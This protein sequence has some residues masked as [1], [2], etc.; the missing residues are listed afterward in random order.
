MR[1]KMAKVVELVF[2]DNWQGLYIDDKLAMCDHSLD[3]VSVLKLL[4]GTVFELWKNHDAYG[5][6]H[7]LP[8][9]INDLIVDGETK[10]LREIYND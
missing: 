3:L 6:E 1:M 9:N 8:E 4:Q 10:T 2:Q 5:W 7:D